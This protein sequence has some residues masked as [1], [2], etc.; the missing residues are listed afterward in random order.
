MRIVFMGTPD[1]AAESLRALIAAG[2]EV[3]G[4]FTR[5]DK[6]VGRKQILTAPPVKQVALEHGI[7]VYQP[8]TLRDGSA[9]EILA[10]LAPELIVV[11]AYGRILPVSVLQLPK[12]GCINL[13]VSLL[14]KYRGSAPVQWSVI[15]GDTETGVTIMQLDEGVDTGDI[16]CVAPVKIGENE[17][18]GELFERISALGAQTLCDTVVAIE[19]GE[20]TPVPQDHT[21]ATHAPQLTKEMGYFDFHE[22]AAVLHNLIRGLNPWPVASFLCGEKRVK[23]LR[24]T[25]RQESGIPGTI[26]SLKPLVIACENGS[27]CLEEVVPE[28]SRS[29][30]GEVWAMGRRFS[31]GDRIE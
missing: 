2:H 24:S 31:V 21:K 28:G 1:I 4:V 5:E 30:S 29:M 25:L 22:D 17:T 11:V 15:N 8:K 9:D 12:Y 27:L 10:E 14:P 18:A 19:K 13:H 20:V 23:V 16:L 6:P 26:L 3:C 7:P